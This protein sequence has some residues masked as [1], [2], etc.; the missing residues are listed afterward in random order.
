M[1][2]SAP[3]GGSHALFP[4]SFDPVTLGHLEL[5]RRAALL[6][7]RVTVAVAHHPTK[8]ELLPFEARLE[9]LREVTSDLPGVQVTRLEGLVVAGARAVGAGVI[10]RGARS[11]SDFDYE[12][13]M[14]RTNRALAPEIETVVLASSPEHV[15]VSST[16]V[17]QVARMGGELSSF[18][19][20]AAAR[21]LAEHLP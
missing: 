18:V 17:R 8:S 11:S 14:A 6:F 9:L 10:V 13:Q 21:A 5:I 7:G 4:G 3:G 16:L 19:P 15:H 12:A 1:S 2:S 20:P